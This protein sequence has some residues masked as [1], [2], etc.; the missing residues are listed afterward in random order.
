[1]RQTTWIVD[2]VT[3]GGVR[4]RKS[5]KLRKYANAFRAKIEN[6]M[7]EGIYKEIKKVSLNEL[8]IKYAELYGNQIAYKTSK[9]FAMKKQ[10]ARKN[11]RCL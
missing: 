8:I 7:N 4:K 9:V 3:P 1:M 2:W 5:F 6:D 10:R 11:G